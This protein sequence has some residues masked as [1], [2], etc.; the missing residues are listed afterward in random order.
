MFGQSDRVGRRVRFGRLDRYLCGFLRVYYSHHGLARKQPE[1]AASYY[2]LAK[3][4]SDKSP[5]IEEQ[6]LVACL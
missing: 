6:N 1:S 5:K 2:Q 4:Y 3:L